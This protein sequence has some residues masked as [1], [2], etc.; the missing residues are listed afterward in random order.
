MPDGQWIYLLW[1]YLASPRSLTFSFKKQQ[2]QQQQQRLGGAEGGGS[3]AGV[4]MRTK[5]S[6]GQGPSSSSLSSNGSTST[7]TA[8]TATLVDIARLCGRWP[9]LPTFVDRTLI[10]MLVRLDADLPLLHLT[11]AN[12]PVSRKSSIRHLCRWT[13]FFN[14]LI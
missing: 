9:I 12:L 6:Q 3:V 10:P 5:L 1:S 8:V 2:Q 14:D 7:T 13:H 4:A 11:K